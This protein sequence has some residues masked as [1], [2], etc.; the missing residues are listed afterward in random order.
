MSKSKNCWIKKSFSLYKVQ[1]KNAMKWWEQTR[2]QA[3][4]N[5][6][7][8]IFLRGKAFFNIYLFIII[9][10]NSSITNIGHSPNYTAFGWPQTQVR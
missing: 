9:L 10:Y 2:I 3:D 7:R 6:V 4:E 5:R 8:E 1:S